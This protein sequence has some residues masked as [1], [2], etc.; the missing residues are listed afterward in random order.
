[1]DKNNS[2]IDELVKFIDDTRQGLYSDDLCFIKQ[3][4]DV[5]YEYEVIE[6]VD[7]VSENV[8][9]YGLSY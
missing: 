4:Q 3:L 8:I 7:R 2:N 1:M 9:L 6:D 5:R